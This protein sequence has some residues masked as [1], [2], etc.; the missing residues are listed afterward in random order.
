M[1]QFGVSVAATV[2]SQPPGCT[3]I[4][5]CVEVGGKAGGLHWGQVNYRVEQSGVSSVAAAGQSAINPRRGGGEVA[6][7]A[8]GW[9]S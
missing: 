1:M 7:G 3:T 9:S 2:L 6:R 5:P 4:N 8:E